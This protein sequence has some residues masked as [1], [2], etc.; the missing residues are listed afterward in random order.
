MLRIRWRLERLAEL[1]HTGLESQQ[2][3]GAKLH[4]VYP[5]E[6]KTLEC[7]KAMHEAEVGWS[8]LLGESMDGVTHG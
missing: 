5:G 2:C 1:Y 4:E 7:M 8:E 3:G 6:T